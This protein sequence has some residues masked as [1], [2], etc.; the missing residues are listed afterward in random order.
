MELD[1]GHV[2]QSPRDTGRIELIVRR[3]D[4]GQRELVDE[5]Q[6]DLDVGRVGDPLRRR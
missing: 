6:L 1:L 3:P 2:R 5:A 4:R